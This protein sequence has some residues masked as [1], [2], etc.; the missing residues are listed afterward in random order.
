[1]TRG[2]WR[3]GAR[4]A[5][6]T[7][8]VFPV[9]PPT[10]VDRGTGSWAMTFAPVV[11]LPLAAVSL[12]AQWLLGWSPFGGLSYPFDLL[13]GQDL[14]LVRPAPALL[15]AALTIGALTLL[16]RGLH[17][18]GLADTADGLGCGK[19][20]DRALEVMRRSDIGPFGVA[21]LVLVLLAQVLALG[22]QLGIGR[23]SLALGLALVLSR[24]VLPLICSYGVPAARADGLGHVVAGSVR[25]SQLAL[26]AVLAVLS[27]AVATVM[28]V[29]V[30]VDFVRLAVLAG[31]VTVV[32]LGCGAAMC[33]WCVRRL[34]GVTGDV[35]G[36]CVEVTF[37]AT[38]VTLTML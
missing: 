19:P 32:A 2:S 6:G 7:L 26:S 30:H 21:T 20:A 10:V 36:A 1:M 17:L 9:R 23:G 35:L 5:V 16:T 15:V 33:S 22:Q 8:T 38:L 37:T 3:D 14:L 25:R 29:G 11:A 31:L 34:G 13:A 18:D 12:L 4:L 24:A 27:L 28:V